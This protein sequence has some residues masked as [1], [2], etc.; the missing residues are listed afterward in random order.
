LH[1][2]ICFEVVF[3]VVTFLFPSN[4]EMEKKWKEWKELKELVFSACAARG[5]TGMHIAQERLT[6]DTGDCQSTFL[7]SVKKRKKEI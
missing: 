4:K 1:E 5:A 6:R 7:E 3:V 2:A